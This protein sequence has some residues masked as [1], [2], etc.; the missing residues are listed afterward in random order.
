MGGARGGWHL[1]GLGTGGGMGR[2]G[3]GWGGGR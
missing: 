3:V 1:W 2:V